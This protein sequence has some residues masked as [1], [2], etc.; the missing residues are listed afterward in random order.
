VLW[1]F[2]IHNAQCTHVFAT[3]RFAGLRGFL[4]TFIPFGL[5]VAAV[6]LLGVGLG[7]SDE[8]GLPTDDGR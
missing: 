3:G 4:E 6:L 7:D 8:E 2:G 1:L 5:V